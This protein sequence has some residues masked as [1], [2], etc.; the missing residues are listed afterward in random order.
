VTRNSNSLPIGRPSIFLKQG[1]GRPTDGIGRGKKQNRPKIESLEGRRLKETEHLRGKGILG[2]SAVIVFESFINDGNTGR[3]KVN[4]KTIG[5]GL[6]G[7][8][9]CSHQTLRKFLHPGWGGGV[10]GRNS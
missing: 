6:E 9:P 3:G 5:K 1:K 7:N 8:C 2:R 4:G 10:L